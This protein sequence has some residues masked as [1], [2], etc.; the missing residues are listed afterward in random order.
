MNNTMFVWRLLQF[1]PRRMDRLIPMRIVCLDLFVSLCPSGKLLQRVGF[2]CACAQELL[3][4][5]SVPAHVGSRLAVK[6]ASVFPQLMEWASKWNNISVDRFVLRTRQR[7]VQ[8]QIWTSM[9][10]FGRRRPVATGSIQIL[11]FSALAGL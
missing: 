3:H 7:C 9:L 10:W 11:C 2:R 4:W 8:A 1:G 5:G 6:W